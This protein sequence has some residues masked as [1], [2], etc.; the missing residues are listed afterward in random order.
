SACTP[1]RLTG[2]LGS[3]CEV[4]GTTPVLSAT[5][6]VG[7]ATATA[8][9]DTGSETVLAFGATEI[10]RPAGLLTKMPGAP[11][12]TPSPSAAVGSLVR[13]AGVAGSAAAPPLPPPPITTARPPATAAIAS[14]PPAMSHVRRLRRAPPFSTDG[15]WKLVAP[16]GRFGSAGSAG[17]GSST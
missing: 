3:S 12:A 10:R 11:A 1:G 13:T 2:I 16:D 5:K 7:P 14:A 8:R 4:N 6:T 15:H 9:G 17:R